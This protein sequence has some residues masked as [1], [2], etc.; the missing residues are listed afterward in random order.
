MVSREQIK[1][2]LLVALPDAHVELEDM[3]GTSDHF[4]ATVVSSAFE[5]KSRI[6]QHKMV[7]AALGELMASEIH[8]LKLKTKTP[9]AWANKSRIP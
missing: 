7:Y 3:T 2:R 9:D 5:G 6:D 8:A 4:D 1:E